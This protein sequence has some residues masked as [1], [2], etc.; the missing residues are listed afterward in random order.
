[1]VTS[2]KVN[3]MGATHETKKNGFDDKDESYELQRDIET[4]FDLL[5]C[6]H[7]RRE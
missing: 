5:L 2:M 1:M 3:A 4:V 7:T 6:K